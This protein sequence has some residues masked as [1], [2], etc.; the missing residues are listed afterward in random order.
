M[1]KLKDKLLY[2]TGGNFSNGVT[3]QALT[4]FLIFFGTSILGVSGTLIGLVVAIS[5]VWDA[6]SDPFIGHVS[7]FTSSKRFGRRHLYMIIGTIGLALTNAALW[8]INPQWSEL[9]KGMAIF[10]GGVMLVKTFM[11]IYVTPY[12]ALGGELS[13]DYYERNSIQ[14]YRTIFF[15]SGLAFTTVAGMLIYFR[16][17]V[18][19]DIG[20]LNPLAYRYLGFTISIMILICGAMAILGTFK[21]I[22]QLPK[23]T[24][25]VHN[26]KLGPMIKEFKAV[27]SNKNYLYVAGG[28]YLSANLATAIVG[29]IGLHVFTYTF[30]M[31]NYG[32]GI[33]F[34]LI[35]GLSIVSQAFYIDITK[36]YDKKNSCFIGC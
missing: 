25:T 24:K 29:A 11:T 13:Q 3:L 8:S 12:N 28:A 1:I 31:D 22:G 21:F 34:G 7:D 10:L 27:F 16:P 5:V 15:I 36:K 18:D 30:G 32:I 4:S 19:F 9:Q 26:T 33:M 17:T 35:F 20:Q 14:A 6:I 2:A 23:N